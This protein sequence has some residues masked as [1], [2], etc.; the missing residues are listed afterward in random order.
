MHTAI[1]ATHLALMVLCVF[2][3]SYATTNTF[4]NPRAGTGWSLDTGNEYVYHV[5]SYVDLIWN[6]SYTSISLILWQN[7]TLDHYNIFSDV[8]AMN[9]YTWR[10]SVPSSIF[11]IEESN[12]EY[13]AA[14]DRI[15]WC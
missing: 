2:R 12:C 7:H 8:P 6:T 11:D 9:E 3:V 13:D 14:E 1:S 5:G 15:I 4:V 10:V